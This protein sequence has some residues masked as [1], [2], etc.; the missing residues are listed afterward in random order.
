MRL[1]SQLEIARLS[2][3]TEAGVEFGLLEPTAIALRKSIID[4]VSDFRRF[5]LLAG[6]HDFDLQPQGPTSKRIVPAILLT[7]GNNFVRANAS[8]YRPVTKAGDPRVWFSRLSNWADA[9]DILAVANDGD[10]L[11]IFNLTRVDLLRYSETSGALSEFLAPFRRRKFSVV[12]E[13]LSALSAISSKGFIE[14]IGSADTT[15]G[16]LLE[17]EL[18]IAANSSKS[19]DYKGIEIKAAR[20]GRG[21]RHNLFARVPNWEISALKSSREVLDQFGY[22]REGRLQLYC[23]VAYDRPN[24]QTLFLDVAL[25]EL[26]VR[27]RSTRL[28][29]SEVISWEVAALEGALLAK[30]AETF[31]VTA[32]SRRSGSNEQ[33]H[34]TKVEHTAD[35][36][37][38]QLVPLI[39]SRD[40]TLDHLV[41]EKNGAAAERGPLFKLKHGSLPLLFPPSKEYFL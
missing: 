28:Q 16:M 22:V 15:V 14:G 7:D 19:P 9:G 37:V 18:G 21:N 33:F 29:A 27:E 23:T 17:A 25:D 11:V 1:L 32:E 20:G 2:V 39:K 30:H 35:P 12:D 26:V 41:R 8:L 31:W 4:A 36:I 24:P 40:I 5:L 6:V 38:E 10:Q 13:L 3:L 34:F